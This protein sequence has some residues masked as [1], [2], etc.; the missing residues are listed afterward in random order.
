[1]SS[2]RDD[3]VDYRTV[4]RLRTVTG[5]S[6]FQA[7]S[8]VPPADWLQFV[9]TDTNVFLPAADFDAIYRV[10]VQFMAGARTSGVADD[11]GKLLS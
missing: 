10:L 2:L 5:G 1:M 9:G 4:L 6:L 11:A 3:V 8:D 7:F